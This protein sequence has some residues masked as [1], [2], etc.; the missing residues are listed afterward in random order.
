MIIDSSVVNEIYNNLADK[1]S[2]DVFMI[3]LIFL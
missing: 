1:E 3:D 2:K